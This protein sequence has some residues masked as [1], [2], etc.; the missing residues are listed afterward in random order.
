MGCR[1]L[2]W[3]CGEVESEGWS[4]LGDPIAEIG[5]RYSCRVFDGRKLA[6]VFPLNGSQSWRFVEQGPEEYVPPFISCSAIDSP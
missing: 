3:L 5:S 6:L 4:F 2:K 1:W